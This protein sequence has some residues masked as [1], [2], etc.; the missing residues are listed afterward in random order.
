MAQ[1]RKVVCPVK[2]LRYS[3]LSP[4]PVP[5]SY[6]VCKFVANY[7]GSYCCV[8]YSRSPF[9]TNPVK[10]ILHVSDHISERCPEEVSQH[11]T[12]EFY[13]LV[14]IMVLSSSSIQPSFSSR[15]LLAA[16]PRNIALSILLAGC[17][18]RC[19]KRYQ[20]SSISALFSLNSSIIPCATLLPIYIKAS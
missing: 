15:S 19:G 16:S 5:Y 10:L 18:P 9:L 2:E 8:H 4:S 3:N 1:C 7:A 13:C 17:L 20:S 6:C 11:L 14:A 12:G